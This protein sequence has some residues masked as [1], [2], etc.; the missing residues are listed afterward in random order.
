VVQITDIRLADKSEIVILP[1][2]SDHIAV[3]QYFFNDYLR[4]PVD[5]M[6]PHQT[7]SAHAV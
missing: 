5:K 1:D 7:A 2:L 4:P 6:Q 3:D